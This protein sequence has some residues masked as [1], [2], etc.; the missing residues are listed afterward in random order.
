MI[1]R[2]MRRTIASLGLMLLAASA[3]AKE[4]RCNIKSDYDLTIDERSVIFTRDSGQPKWVVMR[5][6]RL[7]LDD[8]WVA[9]SKEDTQRV[10]E[11]ERNARKT[12]PLASE[13]ARDATEIA[14]AALTEVAAGFSNDPANTRTSLDK[15]RKTIDKRLARSISANRFSSEAM[16]EAI[17]QTVGEVVPL[18]IGDIVGGAVRSA[19]TGDTERLK[20]M[21]NL[22]KQIE[23]Q[24]EPRA[25]QLEARAEKLCGNLQELDRLDD[26][27]AYR[28]PDGGRLNLLENKPDQSD[29]TE[30]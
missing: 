29:T 5:Q 20:K 22:D 7:F 9:L 17:G 30:E 28:L 23:A 14:F 1:H 11:F 10:A 15:A 13:I 25:K 18:I 24:V 26:A 8:R 16:G 3:Q 12:M 2:Y 4:I 21:E 19:F 27:L 6:G